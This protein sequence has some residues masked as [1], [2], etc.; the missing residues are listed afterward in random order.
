MEPERLARLVLSRLVEPGHRGLHQAVASLGA[1]EVQR[2]LSAGRRLPGLT[3]RLT[4]GIALR[5]AGLDL[6]ADQRH[7]E[8]CGGRIL[9][10]GDEE[11]PT[12]L[13]WDP[14][15]ATAQGVRLEAPPLVLFVRGPQRLNDLVRRSVAV[16]G[17]RAATRYGE[18]VATELAAGLVVRGWSV[19][20]GGAYGIDAAAHRGALAAD[21]R[22]ASM[23]AVPSAA[24]LSAAALSAAE[25]S[26]V[27]L[28]G[29]RS[30]V[31]QSG[32]RSSSAGS[33]TTA[34][35][36]AVLACG[37]DVS[38]PRGNDRLLRQI[39]ETGLLVSELPPQAAPTRIRFLVRNRLI[40]ALSA[41]TVVVQAAARSGSL[42]TLH[43]AGALG[44]H[45]MVVPGP[46]QDASSAGCHQALREDP[47]GVVLV[48]RLGE[49]LECVGQVGEDAIAP[50]RG[51]EHPRDALDVTV[52]RVLEAVPVRRGAGEASIAQVAGVS[53]LVVQQVLP[54][55]HLAGLVERHPTGGWRLTALG[56]SSPGQAR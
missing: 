34:S 3:R 5:A 37:V 33:S 51:P 48:T 19:V 23:A 35:T 54:S 12:C 30:F 22:P 17:A 16:V 31:E 46:V 47:M 42:S 6:A 40:A 13:D 14:H 21:G 49:V 1:V 11:W 15:L 2:A 18:S 41:G 43:R 9:C 53:A 55:L 56:A 4:D 25:P 38:Y 20:S 10:P 44:R 36:V 27:G 32:D 29:D 24:A 45:R 39:A 26:F 8:A 50:L 7:L 28:S 52:L